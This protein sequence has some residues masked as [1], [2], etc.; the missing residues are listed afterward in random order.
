[1]DRTQRCVV[2]PAELHGLGLWAGDHCGF[3]KGGE[4]DGVRQTSLLRLMA[5]KRERT[6]VLQ[7]CDHRR[8]AKRECEY[9]IDSQ[10]DRRRREDRNQAN[11][12]AIY[13]QRKKTYIV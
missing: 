2:G 8:V 9:I 12:Q 4:E 7:A 3:E 10:P 5:S 1:M 11:K 6:S 13:S